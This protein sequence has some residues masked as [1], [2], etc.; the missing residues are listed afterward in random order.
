M[1][2]CGCGIQEAM[3]R[4]HYIQIYNK[5]S[6]CILARGNCGSHWNRMTKAR[7]TILHTHI[8]VYMCVYNTTY[9]YVCI[10][11]V[12]NMYIIYTIYRTYVC[13]DIPDVR[14]A[15]FNGLVGYTRAREGRTFL[16]ASPPPLTYTRVHTTT[17]TKGFVRW[18]QSLIRQT[19]LYLP[20]HIHQNTYTHKTGGYRLPGPPR[21]GP[22]RRHRF[23]PLLQPPG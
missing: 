9:T 5:N 16:T 8:C 21:L 22:R 17:T 6:P 14:T 3:S 18:K 15:V 4:S 11:Y 7:T 10:K 20:P 2:V 12:Y 23:L 13:V 1:Y 19:P